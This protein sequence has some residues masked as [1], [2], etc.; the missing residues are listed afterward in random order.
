[1]SVVQMICCLLGPWPHITSWFFELLIAIVFLLPFLTRQA[2]K[3]L[4]V[5]CFFSCCVEWQSMTLVFF[6]KYDAE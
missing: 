3:H 2:Q 4:W 6:Q 1:M 5:L